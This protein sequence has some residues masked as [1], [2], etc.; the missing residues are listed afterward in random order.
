MYY[1]HT[2]T[3][4]KPQNPTRHHNTANMVTRYTT[5]GDGAAV[6][7]PGRQNSERAIE[8]G[9]NKTF[10]DGIV[11]DSNEAVDALIKKLQ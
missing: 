2:H 5:K 4:K 1:H 7:D 9:K 8:R 10:L 3:T 6:Q 11:E